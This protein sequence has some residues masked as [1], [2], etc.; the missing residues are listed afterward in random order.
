MNDSIITSRSAWKVKWLPNRT[1]ADQ[2]SKREGAYTLDSEQF[3]WTYYYQRHPLGGGDS[4]SNKLCAM[5]DESFM[6]HVFLLLLTRALQLH[7][8]GSLHTL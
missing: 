3:M 2:G 5:A 8:V 4:E 6:L 7:C 1:E